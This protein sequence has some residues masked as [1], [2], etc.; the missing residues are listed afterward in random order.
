M[1]HGTLFCYC[2]EYQ[3]YSMSDD[4]STQASVSEATNDGIILI[5]LTEHTAC[6]VFL[7]NFHDEPNHNNPKRTR[8]GNPWIVPNANINI[9][10][11]CEIRCAIQIERTEKK[12]LGYYDM[13]SMVRGRMSWRTK[14]DVGRGRVPGWWIVEVK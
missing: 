7:D 13:Q 6:F 14:I 4:V 11:R 12:T 8:D 3:L 10:S 5:F 9:S 1:D 2:V